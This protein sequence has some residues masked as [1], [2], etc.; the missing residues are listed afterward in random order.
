MERPGGGGGEGGGVNTNKKRRVHS[1][2]L[3]AKGSWVTS[4]DTQP[5]RGRP[6]PVA[7]TPGTHRCGKRCEGGGGGQL[8]LVQHTHI[9]L[10]YEV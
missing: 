8:L 4:R 1:A 9:H 5:I 7:M 10:L 2:L 3:T 6:A